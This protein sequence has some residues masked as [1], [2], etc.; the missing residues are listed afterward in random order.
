MSDNPMRA[1]IADL[2]RRLPSASDEERREIDET[3][4]ALNELVLL[5]RREHDVDRF[6]L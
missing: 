1:V 5:K 4:T 2:R 6:Y 3:V